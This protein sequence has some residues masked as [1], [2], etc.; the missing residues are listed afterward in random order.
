MSPSHKSRL[1]T[2]GLTAADAFSEDV[3]VPE[4]MS[5]TLSAPPAGE[6]SSGYIT[7]RP[8]T[9]DDV[10]R[11]IGVPDEVGRRREFSCEPVSE[12]ALVDSPADFAKLAQSQR[13]SLRELAKR[14]VYGDS[15]VLSQYKTTLS[16]L[17]EDAFIQGI[18]L[19]ADVDVLPGAQLQ[20]AAN[21]KVFVARRVRIWTGGRIK[22]LGDTKIDCASIVGKYTG[23]HF[24]VVNPVA[25]HL[26][27]LSEFGG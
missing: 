17:L 13:Q 19:G 3:V 10:K 24:P 27:V 16:H 4:G 11:W 22:L 5:L 8:Q 25:L 12:L 2:Y 1:S 21:L 26:G 14:Y 20:I 15:A 18:V 6:D 7:L 23:L 9:I